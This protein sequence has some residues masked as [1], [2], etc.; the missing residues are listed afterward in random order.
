MYQPCVL[1]DAPVL[2]KSPVDE[3]TQQGNSGWGS[4]DVF[5]FIPVKSIEGASAIDVRATER[6]SNEPISTK[7]EESN[8]SLATETRSLGKQ[9]AKSESSIQA[10]ATRREQNDEPIIIK[11][12]GNTDKTSD[13]HSSEKLTKISSRVSTETMERNSNAKPQDLEEPEKPVCPV[14]DLD[15]YDKEI[16]QHVLK[17]FP[18]KC[19]SS[20]PPPVTYIEDRQWIRINRTAASMYYPSNVT[21]NCTVR[22]FYR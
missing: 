16:V 11:K 6:Q 2:E 20:Y 7:K 19:E 13:L 12:K 22:F 1:L 4:S 18:A 15:P 9:P 10:D 21:D 5:L 14:P 17:P 3:T 8:I